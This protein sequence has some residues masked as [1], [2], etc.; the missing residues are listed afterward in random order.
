MKLVLISDTHGK[1]DAVSVPD[2]DVLVHAGDMT[3]VGGKNEYRSFATWFAALPHRHKILIAG[4]HDFN[5]GYFKVEC[6][7]Y[8]ENIH[9]LEN[10]SVTIR[11]IKFYG[12]PITPRFGQW[13]FMLPRDSE[14]IRDCWSQIPEDTDVLITHGP[15]YGILDQSIPHYSENVGCENLAERVL[16]LPNLKMHFFGHIHGSYG[17]NV[18]DSACFGNGAMLDESYNFTGRK[19]LEFWIEQ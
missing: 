12:S 5:I 19:P 6:L 2:G 13:A 9:Y 16:K 1:H 17:I 14:E 3:M 4:N 7:P 15:P 8:V 10:E 18:R 11:G